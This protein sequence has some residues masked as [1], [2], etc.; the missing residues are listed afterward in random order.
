MATRNVVPISATW[1]RRRGDKVQLLVELD[2]HWRLLT[3]ESVDGCFSRIIESCQ[4]SG[5]PL[6]PVTEE[7]PEYTS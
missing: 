5:A 3:E 6:D 2:G 4:F 7:R 1:L